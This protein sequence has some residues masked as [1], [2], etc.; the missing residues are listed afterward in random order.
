MR[1]LGFAPL[2]ALLCAAPAGAVPVSFAVSGATDSGA[3]MQGFVTYDDS[4]GGPCRYL[5]CYATGP[6]WIEL[7]IGGQS[8]DYADPSGQSTAQN[9]EDRS[10][11]RLDVF[12]GAPVGQVAE[13]TLEEPGS[14]S[15]LPAGAPGTWSLLAGTER[16]SGTLDTFTPV[17]LRLPSP[18]P[19]PSSAALAA[20]ALG[21]LLAGAARFRRG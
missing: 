10:F 2:L 7:T 8:F 18:V 21:G 1:R 4:L 13:L 17:A 20:V 11:V 15:G 12:G 6:G 5:S 9:S 3:P 14:F 19:A 16:F